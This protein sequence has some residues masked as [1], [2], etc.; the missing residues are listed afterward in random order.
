MVPGLP[1]LS[2]ACPRQVARLQHSQ[3]E[4]SGTGAFRRWHDSGGRPPV[5]LPPF[6]LSRPANLTHAVAARLSLSDIG[7]EPSRRWTRQFLLSLQLSWKLAAT[8]T[9][10]RPS[11]ADIA[12]ERTLSA[13]ARHLPVRSI[14]NLTGSHLEPGRDSCAHRSSRRARVEQEGPA[15]PRLRLARLRHGHACC[16]HEER[17]VDT[18]CL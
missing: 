3:G 16:K 6:A 10:S 8:C 18:D 1:R 9:R 12:R 4:A 5:D 14:Q 17:H 15:S 11:E 13:A 7:F 2:S